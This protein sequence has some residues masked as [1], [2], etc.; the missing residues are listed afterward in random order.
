[1]KV[2]GTAEHA[3][4]DWLEAEPSPKSIHFGGSKTFWRAESKA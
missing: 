3:V 4:E 1:M 2:T